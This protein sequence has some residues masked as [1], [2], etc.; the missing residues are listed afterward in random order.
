MSDQPDIEKHRHL[1]WWYRERHDFKGRIIENYA[2]IEECVKCPRRK[3]LF[4]LGDTAV[5][6][7]MF[8]LSA[9][10]QREIRTQHELD[11]LRR[12]VERLEAG[13]P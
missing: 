7:S 1:C 8:G 5:N 11:K 2:H 13:E 3:V 10:A 9:E 4:W 6:K 12:R